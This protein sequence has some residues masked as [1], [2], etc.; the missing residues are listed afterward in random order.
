MDLRPACHAPLLTSVNP[1]ETMNDDDP[2][3]TRPAGLLSPRRIESIH[4]AFNQIFA[5][6]VRD[7]LI[8]DAATYMPFDQVFEL[9]LGIDKTMFPAVKHAKPQLQEHSEN[10]IAGKDDR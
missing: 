3:N 5:Q 9:A 6:G 1:S 10:S 8:R 2:P 7:G 4:L